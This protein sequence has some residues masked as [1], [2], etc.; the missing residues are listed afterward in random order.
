MQKNRLLAIGLTSFDT[1][2]FDGSF[3]AINPSGLDAAG[4][5]LRI[6]NNSNK[7][8]TVSFDGTTSHD[9]VVSGSTL[10]L[11][12]PI[13]AYDRADFAKGTVIYLNGAVG[14]G[15][16]YLSGYYVSLS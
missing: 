10:Q 16:V 9:L 12:A 4:C 15:Y 3:D 1:S 5:M 2:L 6:V 13:L 7:D 8:V 11:Y 14:T